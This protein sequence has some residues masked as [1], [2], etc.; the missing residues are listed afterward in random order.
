MEPTAI[1]APGT[2]SS[3]KQTEVRAGAAI[4]PVSAMQ[5]PSDIEMLRTPAGRAADEGSDAAEEEDGL[6]AGGDDDDDDDD[7]DND[8]DVGGDHGMEGVQKTNGGVKRKLVEDEDY[9]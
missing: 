8:A 3:S 5:T 4:G 2:S 7:D 9:D 6:F 1:P